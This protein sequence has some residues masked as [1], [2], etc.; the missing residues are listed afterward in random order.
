MVSTNTVD[1]MQ[2]CFDDPNCDMFY[3]DV[4]MPRFFRCESTASLEVSETNDILYLK[5]GNKTY[6]PFGIVDTYVL[7]QHKT[8][9]HTH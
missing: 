6:T 5:R 3:E 8:H 2:E 4:P 9:T 1:A 7:E